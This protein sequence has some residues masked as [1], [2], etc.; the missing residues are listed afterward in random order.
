MFIEHFWGKTDCKTCE[1]VVK[2]LELKQD[3]TSLL[4]I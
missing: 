3:I 1:E 2:E 4:L